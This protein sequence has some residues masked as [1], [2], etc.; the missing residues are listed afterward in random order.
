MSISDPFDKSSNEHACH[1]Y[2]MYKDIEERLAR[3]RATPFTAGFIQGLPMGLE[4]PNGITI[5]A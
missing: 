4:L 5:G 2:D 1:S 3:R